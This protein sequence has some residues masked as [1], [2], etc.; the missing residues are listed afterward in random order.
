[1]PKRVDATGLP[2]TPCQTTWIFRNLQFSSQT[3]FLWS[4]LLTTVCIVAVPLASSAAEGNAP[5]PKP[6]PKIYKY[7]KGGTPSF[8][9]V[10]PDI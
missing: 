3:H 7:L 9:D 4:A 1:M 2:Y 8:S 10:P 6:G 5:A